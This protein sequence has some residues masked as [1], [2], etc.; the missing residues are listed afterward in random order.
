[1]IASQYE[2]LS[3]KALKLLRLTAAINSVILALVIGVPLFILCI[4][5]LGLYLSALLAILPGVVFFILLVLLVAPLRVRRY[6][7]LIAQDRIEIIE[8]LL[9]VSRKII[10]VDRIHQI[11]ILRGPLDTLTGV[12]KVVVTTAGSQS[13]FRF[14]EP[15]RAETL[16]LYLNETIRQKLQNARQRDVGALQG[17]G[18]EADA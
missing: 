12:A 4:P 14:L 6:R 17:N 18:G 2:T 3:G 8:G 11:D 16:A 13:A 9:F 15:E 10:P 5:Y 1:M 7:Y